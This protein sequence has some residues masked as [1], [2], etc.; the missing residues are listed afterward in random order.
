MLI[1][2]ANAFWQVI[3]LAGIAWFSAGIGIALVNVY[4]S[5][6]STS[7]KRGRSFS[8]TFMALPLASLAAAGALL[9]SLAGGLWVFWLATAMLFAARGT[10]GVVATA[11]ATDL[12]D[13]DARE[14]G[15]PFLNTANYLAG[16]LGF[17]AAGFLIESAGPFTLYAAL[18]IASAASIIVPILSQ[19]RFSIPGTLSS[20]LH[21][22]GLGL[23][24]SSRTVAAQESFSQPRHQR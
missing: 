20:N 6:Y 10:N 14:R 23:P 16:I 21:A 8:L 7:S 4:T 22:I 24:P 17:A 15:L 19:A 1:G 3:L 12:L 11:M 13:A 9:L 2:Q 18:A 5:L